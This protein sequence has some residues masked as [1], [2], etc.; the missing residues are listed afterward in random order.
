[1]KGVVKIKNMRIYGFHGCLKEESKIGGDYLVTLKAYCDMACAAETDSLEET[2][3][4]TLLAKI[5]TKEMAV[6]SKLLESVAKR[7]IDSCLKKAPAI[8]R[9][10]VEI[11]K[12]NPPIN[13]DVESVVVLMEGKRE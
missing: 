9:V 11:N 8:E 6:K 10:E 1:M 7:I 4:Y 13:A 12:I 3:N 2:A 5:I